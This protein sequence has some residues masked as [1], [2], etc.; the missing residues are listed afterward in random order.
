MFE[1]L[2]L[3]GNF[4]FTLSLTVM[5]I[6]AL[7]EGAGLVVGLAFSSM[8]ETLLPDL[9][10]D[11]DA[12]D[13]PDSG[14]ISR[15]LGWFYI[16]QVPFLVLLII[17]LTY[18]GLAGLFVQSMYRAVTGHLLYNWLAIIPATL[19]TLP[20]TRVSVKGVASVLPKDESEAVSSDSFIGRVAVVTTGTARV[21]SP[22]QAKVK[23]QHGQTH[24]LMVEPD[25]HQPDQ[26]QG[27]QV[28]IIKQ[29]QSTFIVIPNTNPNL[30]N[31]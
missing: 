16:G 7:L 15:I 31:Q 18:F 24:Y 12:A 5:V 17:L 1:F 20:L 26:P 13:I 14:L 23:D 3:S 30:V 25:K 2:T 27:S 21:G 29:Q 11:V 6:L 28:L 19:L 9:S 8:L 10:V 4:P 22:A